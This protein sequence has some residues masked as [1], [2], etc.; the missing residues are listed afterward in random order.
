LTGAAG[1]CRVTDGFWVFDAIV[2]ARAA[3]ALWFRERSNRRPGSP[4]GPWISTKAI[5]QTESFES[6]IT[7]SLA[8]VVD[9][10]HLI[11]LV[12]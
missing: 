1:A 12:A 6:A 4:F 11:L 3:Q 2:L 9:E 10:R 8:S 5:E 7:V